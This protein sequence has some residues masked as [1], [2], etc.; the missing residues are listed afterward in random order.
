MIEMKQIG[1]NYK[2]AKRDAGFKQAMKSLFHKEYEIVHALND[3]SFTI[4]RGEAVGIIGPNGAGK[5]T[6]IKI[7]SGILTPDCGTCKVEGY[8]PWK[9]RKRYGKRSESSLDN[10]HN[11]GGTCPSLILLNF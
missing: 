5:S 1:K 6:T 10:V 3:I 8:T 7:L 4:E 11:Y 9:D 2:V